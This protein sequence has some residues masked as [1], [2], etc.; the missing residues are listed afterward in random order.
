MRIDPTVGLT[1]LL[2]LGRR[3]REAENAQI[4]GFVTANESRQLLDYRQSAVWLSI[5]GVVTISGLPQVERDTP[6]VHWL[7][8]LAKQV[9]TSA[10]VRSLSATDLPAEWP[11]DLAFDWDDWWPLHALALPL[12][13][14]QQRVFGVWLLARDEAW[15]EDEIEIA[16]ELASIYAH[17]WK[18]FLPQ[19]AWRQRGLVWLRERRQQRR[20]ALAMAFIAV[21]PVRLTV[22]APAEV[23]PKDSF[24]VRAPLEGAVDRMYVRPNQSVKP[25][26]PLFDLDTTGLRTRLSVA[27]KGYEA[28]SEEYRQAAQLAVA[29]DEKGRLEMSQR[30]GRMEEKAA[31]LAYSEQLLDRVQV[32]SPRE[33]VAVFADASDWIGKA[34]TIGERVMQIADPTKVE[35]T[36]RLP[37]A[38][39]IDLEPDASTTLYLTTAPQLSYDAKL[40]YLAYKS[41]ATHEGVVAY[42]LKADFVAE[43]TLPRLG[44]TGTAKIY[45]EWAP[46]AYYLLRR[47]LAAA[48]QWLGW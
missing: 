3:A 29:D 44:L 10:Q 23:T 16:R 17:A 40:T 43:E 21:F 38:D 2:Q 11:S 27:R 14:E 39:A 8:R 36:I 6:Y 35:L 28:A 48:R 31:E 15:T 13:D 25:N 22:L 46:F 45:G 7:N 9:S 19:T 4:L 34:V 33:G 32:K 41:E 24:L 30:K 42:K 5:D 20:I 12:S 37:V 18:I 1:G 47:P 26:Q